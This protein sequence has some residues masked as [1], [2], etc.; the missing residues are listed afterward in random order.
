MKLSAQLLAAEEI[1]ELWFKGP[2]NI[3]LILKDWGKSHRFAGSK[4]R[5][6]IADFVYDSLRCLSSAQWQMDADNARAT[7]LGMLSLT[8]KLSIEDI[9]SLYSGELYS[10]KPLSSKEVQSYIR[11]FPDN[12]PAFILGN[13][14]EFLHGFLDESFESDLV[15]EM[16]AL[17]L[18]APLDIRVNTL[19][20]NRAHVQE[21]LSIFNPEEGEYSPWSLRFRHGDKSRNRLLQHEAYE[22]GFFEVQDEGS[23][24]IALLCKSFL[25]DVV[26]DYCAGAGGKTLALSVL[27][28]NKGTLIASDISSSRLTPLEERKKRAGASNIKI[29]Y[30][31][32]YKDLV[33][34]YK[35]KADFVLLDAPCSGT[36]TWR[37]DPESKWR[38]Q[39][40]VL[41]QRIREQREVLQ[42]ALSLVRSGGHIGYATCSILEKENDEVIRSFLQDNNEITFIS[43]KRVAEEIFREAQGVPYY[44]TKFGI[45]LTPFKTGTDG[46]YLS[47][48][49]KD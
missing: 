49:R 28:N 7:L 16:Q 46:F 40:S 5:A 33:M 35:K 6:A 29:L 22:K 8:H 4:D 23:Q 25:G 17:S 44:I 18:R 43:P 36:G 2:Q 34:D 37:R 19:K 32:Q 45:M 21:E 26:V 13:Y 24:L 20:S 3:S 47:V 1:L 10:P 15:L 27:M 9:N 31:E 48:L 39:L 38:F 12:A 41:D 11:S 14:P 30:P 42:N